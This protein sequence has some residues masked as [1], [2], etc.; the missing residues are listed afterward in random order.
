MQTQISQSLKSTDK[1]PVSSMT[2][3]TKHP[4]QGTAGAAKFSDAVY[5]L[6]NEAAEKIEKI[7]PVAVVA[8]SVDER[9]VIGQDGSEDIELEDDSTNETP[10]INISDVPK[11]PNITSIVDTDRIAAA[12]LWDRNLLEKEGSMEAAHVLPEMFN[13]NIVAAPSDTNLMSLSL[14]EGGMQSRALPISANT[15][16]LSKGNFEHT[17]RRTPVELAL[18]SQQ[19]STSSQG[20]GPLDRPIVSGLTNSELALIDE[21]KIASIQGIIPSR[22]PQKAV[23]ISDS[24]DPLD[25]A[26][27]GITSAKLD[28]FSSKFDQQTAPVDSK[29][30]LNT[31]SPPQVSQISL[32]PV[33]N[34]SKTTD[35]KFT[36]EGLKDVSEIRFDSIFEGKQPQLAG[37]TSQ[38]SR[39]EFATPV[40]R[41]ITDAIHARLTNAKVIEVALNPAELGRLKLSMSPA[42]NGLVVTILADRPEVIDLM[43]RNIA[44]LEQ[45]FSDM[46]H[47]NISFSFEQNED[48]TD[49]DRPN[50]ADTTLE[51]TDWSEPIVTSQSNSIPQ[52]QDATVTS[53]VDIRI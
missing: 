39:P 35:P 48:R 15:T 46:G 37:Q 21:P 36:Q 31:N 14:A 2:T 33:A 11:N 3:S 24:S 19:N 1:M 42:E 32:P 41:Q 13:S 23:D 26:E 50:H 45:A 20:I 18:L 4:I 8:A 27:P 52:K 25:L 47:E 28:G 44:D 49:Q 29:A 9:D 16:N 17:V 12:D 38:V 40:T 43:R 5:L 51:S 30:N 34:H 6:E 7:Q 22:T 53:G 10:V